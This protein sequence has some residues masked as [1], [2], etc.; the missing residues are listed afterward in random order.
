MLTAYDSSDQ[1]TVQIV[2]SSTV[3]SL[4]WSPQSS[5]K[6]E[7]K[8]NKENLELNRIKTSY[9]LGWLVAC[10]KITN[11]LEYVYHT[12]GAVGATS[13]LLIVPDQKLVIAVLCNLQ[14]AGEI[15][16]FTLRISRVFS[17]KL[18]NFLDA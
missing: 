14:S 1:Q 5:M 10:D 2:K 12:G 7:D 4:L 16:K 11:K 17:S 9:G 15:V 6:S 18:Q 13:C 8:P 3:K